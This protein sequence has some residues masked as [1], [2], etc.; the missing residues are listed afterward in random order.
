MLHAIWLFAAEKAEPDKTAFYIIGP[1]LPVWAVVL[2]IGGL[3]NPE[4]PKTALQARLIMAISAG[5][6][7][8]VLATA[9]ITS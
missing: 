2:A 7:A 6:V 3:R 5:L 9:V 4:M 8:V 1:L